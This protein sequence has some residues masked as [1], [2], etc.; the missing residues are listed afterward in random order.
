MFNRLPRNPKR[1]PSMPVQERRDFPETYGL[2]FVVAKRKVQ[3]IGL[4]TDSFRDRWCNWGGHHQLDAAL[5]MNAR[6]HFLELRCNPTKLDE[7]ETAAIRRWWPPLNTA[8]KSKRFKPH[9]HPHRLPS[10]WKE[11]LWP[12]LAALAALAIIALRG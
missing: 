2:Y 3:Y 11:W 4:T 1:L 9:G 7:L 8:K 10:R 5:R 12:S 6:V